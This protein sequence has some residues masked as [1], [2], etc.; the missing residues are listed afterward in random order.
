MTTA[1]L[2]TSALV[3]LV[4]REP[5][6]ELAAALWNRAPIVATSRTSDVELRAVLAAGARRGLLDEDEH[7]AALEAWAHLWPALYVVETT[8]AVTD[9]AAE[10]VAAHPLRG[11]DAVHLASALLLAPDVVVAVWDEHVAAAA[12]AEGL[13][14]LPGPYTVRERHA[15]RPSV[16]RASAGS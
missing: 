9:R 10:L 8:P 11:G 15:P 2:D 3:R 4:R 12:E 5:G 16:R 6:S 1:Y 14:V 7:A 13:V